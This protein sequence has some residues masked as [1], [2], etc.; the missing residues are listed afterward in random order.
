MDSRQRYKAFISYSH[1]DRK[2][3]EWLHRALETYRAPRKVAKADDGDAPRDLRPIFR[4]KAELAASSDLNEVIRGALDRSDTLILLC[5]PTAAQSRW[6]NEEAAYFLKGRDHGSVICVITPATPERAPLTD[7]LPPALLAALPEGVEPLAVDLRE[8]ADGKRLARLKIAA[9]L[10][11]VSLDQLVQRDARRR[12]RLMTA[13]TAGAAVIT[14]GM[15]AMTVAT[16]KSR[17][18]AREQRDETEALV[19]YMLGDLRQQLE[20]V[21]RLDVLDGVSAK[22]LAYYAKPRSDRLDDNALAQRAKAQTLLGTIREQRGDLKGAEDAFGQAAATT[23]ALV[24]RDPANGD[25][26]FDEAQNVFWLAYMESRRG[27]PAGAEGGFKRYGELADQLVRLDPHRAEWRIEVGYAKNN[28][29]TLLFEQNRP[30]EALK[31]FGGALK[32]F[33]AERVLKPTDKARVLDTANSR[34]W[35]ADSLLKLGR[36]REAHVERA[37]SAQLM[38]DALTRDPSDKRL[39]VRSIAAELALARLELDLGRVDDARGR[40]QAGMRRLGDLEKLDPTNA[41]W[42]EYVLVGLLDAVDLSCW[43]GRRAEAGAIHA[44]AVAKLAQ[45]R[46][47]DQAK[48]WRPDLDGR[49]VQQAIVLARLDHDDAKARSLAAGLLEQLKTAPKSRDAEVENAG[50]KAFAQLA[51]GQPTEAVA[52]LSLRRGSLSP[53]NRDVLARA[54]LGVGQRNQAEKVVSELKKQGYQ[55][56]AFLDF[57]R[58]SP[59]GGILQA[60]GVK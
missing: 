50:V 42:R 31:A 45:L 5:S 2:I 28:L 30:A 29:G 16:L 13:F 23:H 36:V 40:S 33:E 47:G 37:A 49:L 52:T 20:P 58:D 60:E 26:I 34:A 11:N 7:V 1:H 53:A 35:M 10:L 6:V 41:R 9:R 15:G 4:D 14:I 43:S 44:D 38:A 3:A 54:Y 59:A 56:P 48:I 19:A 25:R 21:G 46:V 17:Q 55:H 8:D 22:V 32:V 18:I 57:W 12:L 39:A 51:A 24:E 27:D